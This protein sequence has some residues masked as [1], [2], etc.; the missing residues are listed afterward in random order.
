LKVHLQNRKLLWTTAIAFGVAGVA[1][2]LNSPKKTEAPVSSVLAPKSIEAKPHFAVVRPQ[3]TPTVS[4][5]PGEAAVQQVRKLFAEDPQ[6]QDGRA[7]ELLN[8]YCREGK[9]QI[10]WKLV[11]AVPADMQQDWLSIVCARWAEHQP[12]PAMNAVAS[13]TDPVQREAAFQAA[14]GGWN[15]HDPAGLADYALN[16]PASDDRT[17]ALMQAMGNWSMQN[18]AAMAEWLNTLPRGDA[19][20]YG[21]TLML[22]RSDGANRPPEL[23]M[24]WVENISNPAYKQ[25]SFQRVLAE[26]MQTDANAARQY[27]ATASWLDDATRAK[28]LAGF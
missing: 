25:S 19:Y 23:A 10:A 4:I 28:V 18:P 11:E 9:F 24:K 8:E 1:A 14:V 6:D 20:D 17:L 3:M 5:D 2:F 15:S 21:V 22:S 12:W 7:V 26:W 27:V 16:M 13:I